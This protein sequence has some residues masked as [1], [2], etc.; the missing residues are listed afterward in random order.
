MSPGT[1]HSHTI[2]QPLF[3]FNASSCPNRTHPQYRRRMGKGNVENSARLGPYGP[4]PTSVPS[5]ASACMHPV[6]M[7]SYPAALWHVAT[8]RRR[9]AVMRLSHSYAV[10]PLLVRSRAQMLDLGLPVE[11]PR[12]GASACEQ[13]RDHIMMRN[14]RGLVF[15]QRYQKGV[16]GSISTS[17]RIMIGQAKI[18][19]TS[20][21]L[22]ATE[23]RCL[24]QRMHPGHHGG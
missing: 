5:S 2:E 11:K 19:N 14:A 1:A 20:M 18:Y 6:P 8:Y 15:R 3:S 9:T 22:M 10:I 23:N 17:R 4:I 16:L 24:P 7:R 13:R 12:L 21:C